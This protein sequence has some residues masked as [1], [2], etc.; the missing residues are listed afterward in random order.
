MTLFWPIL[1]PLPPLTVVNLTQKCEEI[2]AEAIKSQNETW[3]PRGY[4]FFLLLI[5]DLQ[6]YLFLKKMYFYILAEEHTW[7]FL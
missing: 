5:L 3:T 7:Y 6:K 2:K 4:K 1:D